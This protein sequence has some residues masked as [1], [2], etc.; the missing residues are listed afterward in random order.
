MQ[1]NGVNV[2]E[3]LGCIQN[4]ALSFGTNGVEALPSV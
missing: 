2:N 3:L 4:L 1:D